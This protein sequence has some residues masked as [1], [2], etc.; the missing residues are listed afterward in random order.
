MHIDTIQATVTSAAVYLRRE[1]ADL[2]SGLS[3]VVGEF[4]LYT[5]K[6]IQPLQLST[7]VV[8]LNFKPVHKMLFAER[9]FKVKR[10]SS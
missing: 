2:G 8:G 6:G 3:Y 7:H 9:F 5:T 10:L 1:I 4:K